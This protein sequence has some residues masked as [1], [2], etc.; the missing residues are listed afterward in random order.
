M[1]IYER[2]A[3][4]WGIVFNASKCKF[5]V[6]GSRKHDNSTFLL[7]N[8]QIDSTDKFKYLFLKFSP[9]LNMSDFFKDKFHDVKN[10]CFSL[11]SFGFKSNDVSH[12]LFQ[13]FFM[14]LRL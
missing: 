3:R 4:K 2:F 10:S 9:D 11:N 8:I 5:T 12:F 14:G 6:L 13:E 7:N 1:V